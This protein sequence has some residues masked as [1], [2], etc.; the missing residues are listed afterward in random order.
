MPMKKRSTRLL[1]VISAAAVFVAVLLILLSQISGRDT[2]TEDRV[3]ELL[4][5]IPQNGTTLGTEE[6]PVTIYLYEDLQCPACAR[7]TRSTSQTSSH[8]T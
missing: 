7:F 4:A 1:I 5:D 6:A 8:A 3:Q 2:L